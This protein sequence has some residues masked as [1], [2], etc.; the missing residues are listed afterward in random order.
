MNELKEININSNYNLI[1]QNDIM[2][3][4]Y[5][6]KGHEYM[7]DNKLE[8]ICRFAFDNFLEKRM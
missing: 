1:Y 8:N 5:L 6:I 4:I 7:I 2:N 3:I